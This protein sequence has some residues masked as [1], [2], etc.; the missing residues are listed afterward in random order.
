MNT[1]SNDKEDMPLKDS[2]GV[3]GILG[4]EFIGVGPTMQPKD[5]GN[6]PELKVTEMPAPKKTEHHVDVCIIGGGF[7]GVAA[8]IECKKSGKS[9]LLVDKGS[10]GFSG[11][12]PWPHTFR[13]FDEELGDNRETHKEAMKR[14]SEYTCNQSWYDIWM[15]ESKDMHDMLEEWGFL[16]RWEAAD[17]STTSI[18]EYHEDH[19]D[20]DRHRTFQKVLRSTRL[21]TSN[22]P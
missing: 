8:A 4:G 22:A 18:I 19:A 17:A 21:T 6:S 15:D 14:N 2:T 11:Y 12:A 9:V 10:P 1:M 13:W 7:A 3:E 20:T 5:D 16:Q